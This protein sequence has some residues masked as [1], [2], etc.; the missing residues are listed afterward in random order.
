MVLENATWGAPRIHGELLKLGLDVSERTVSRY[1]LLLYPRDQCPYQ[2]TD[3]DKIGRPATECAGR[4]QF[5]R[6]VIIEEVEAE[7]FPQMGHRPGVM[8]K[9]ADPRAS[10]E[11]TQLCARIGDE[12]HPLEQL[13]SFWQGQA[14]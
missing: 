12:A 2:K 8:F 7:L 14:S 11:I 9:K 6:F 1:L 13:Q 5:C 10:R 4:L 3:L